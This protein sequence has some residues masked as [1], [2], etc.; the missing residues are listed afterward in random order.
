MSERAGTVLKLW[1]YPVKSVGGEE[2]DRLE[3]DARGV[4]GDRRYAVLNAEGRP[5]S[6]KTTRRFRQIDGL[7]E[8]RAKYQGD[9][10]ELLFTDGT[11]MLGSDPH[12]HAAL[13]KA[14]RKPVTLAREQEISHLDAGPVHVITTAGLA[15]LRATLPDAVIDERRFRPNLVIEIPGDTQVERD[16]IGKSLSIGDAVK[17]SISDPTERCR[18]VALAQ[19][20]LPYDPRV[21]ASIVR[22]AD[23]G[24]GVYADIVVPGAISL[25][26]SC[27]LA[28]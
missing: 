26:D 22:E 4:A 8:L 16:W 12:I 1:R 27:T 25:N 9:E 11:R 10:P 13:S 14:L 6:G 24:F 18:M 5:G 28:P 20:A 15:W 23:S 19:G 7:L 2:C 21:L 17:L 3:L